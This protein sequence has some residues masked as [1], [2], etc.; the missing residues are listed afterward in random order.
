[1]ITETN[2]IIT[3][4]YDNKILQFNY[5]ERKFVKEGAISTKAKPKNAE[6]AKKVTAST[7]SKYPPN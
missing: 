3:V 1:M 4:G 7:L 6:K 5:K 2:K